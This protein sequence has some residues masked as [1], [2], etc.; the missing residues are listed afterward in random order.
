LKRRVSA[1]D[2]AYDLALPQ[3]LVEKFGLGPE[4]G[5]RLTVD[6]VV[7]AT[8]LGA[9]SLVG[10][11]DDTVYPIRGQTVLVKSDLAGGK[12]KRCYMGTR[13]L[14]VGPD[15]G[16][17]GIS[18]PTL[19][20]AHSID[21]LV[22]RP[23]SDVIPGKPSVPAYIIP[24]PGPS[25]H[26]ILGGTFVKNE[27]NTSPDLAVSERI[28]RDCF[29]LNPDL[30]GPQRPGKERSW[31]DI[32]VV[33]HNVG[34]RP[35]REAGVRVE[36]EERSSRSPGKDHPLIPGP[37]TG[38]TSATRTR[39]K[40]A[41]VHA[42]GIGPA[43]FQASLGIAEEASRLADEWLRAGASGQLVKSKL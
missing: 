11:E 9:K 10:V 40:V 42:Y 24:R 27:W 38:R 18:F 1:L 7:N 6:L 19:P 14:N 39:G 23:R 31:R 5:G 13:N 8:G 34:L 22:P 3:H 12:G 2:E 16:S 28:L 37:K 36:L 41:V 4:S 26:V 21:T 33:S 30:A 29:K 43:G 25:N 35:A 20:Q 17:V 32:E 15:G